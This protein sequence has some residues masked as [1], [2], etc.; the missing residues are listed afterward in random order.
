M[1]G[2][3]WLHTDQ[4]YTRND[5]ECVQ[6][7][8]TAKDVNKGDATLCFMEKSHT[9]HETIA[10]KFE[11]TDKSDWFKLEDKH[12]DAYLELGCKIRRIQCPKGAM[13]LWD[14]RTIHCGQ[15]G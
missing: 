14:S 3:S 7:W 11:I 15:E 10:K 6:S 1:E 4:S 12:V 5:F 9:F 8:V 2:K 13:V